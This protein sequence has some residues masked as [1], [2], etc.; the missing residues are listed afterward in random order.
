MFKII[1]SCAAI[2]ALAGCVSAP[3]SSGSNSVSA[4]PETCSKSEFASLMGTQIN[5]AALP[6]TLTYR[7]VWTDDVVTTDFVEDR[8]EIAVDGSGII[9]GLRCG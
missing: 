6:L 9:T 2:L 3:K 8:L 4:G 7:V 5:D 1:T